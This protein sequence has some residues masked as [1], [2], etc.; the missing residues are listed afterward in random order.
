MTPP[1]IIKYMGSKRNILDFVVNTILEIKEPTD[2]RFYDVFG[3]TGVVS[4]AFR[5]ILAVTCNDIQNYTSILAK[6]YL[7]NYNWDDFPENIT[8]LLFNQIQEKITENLESNEFD[9]DYSNNITF[10]QFLELEANQKEIKNLDFDSDYHLFTKFYSGTYWSYSQCV[11]IDSISEVLRSD[12][13]LNTFWNH[14]GLSSLMFSMA[15]T[16]IGTGHYAQYRDPEETNMDDFL[17]YR[18]KSVFELFK[19]KLL[20]LIDHFRNEESSEFN[21]EYTNL[22]FTEVLTDLEQNSIVYADPPYQ[23]VHYS[24]FYH[25]LETLVLYDYPEIK[26]KGRYRTDRHQS[27][28]CQ[29]SNV[30]KA[31]ADLFN[32]VFISNSKLILS[33]SNN[34]M[35]S[36]E[37]I[38]LIAENELPNYN[39]E[40]RTMGHTHS[41]M[42]RAKDKSREVEEVLV[43]CLPQRELL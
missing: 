15:Y 7:A 3:G 10:Q 19:K 28:F 4:A 21:H 9:F 13:Y 30:G 22:D 25:A 24:R 14:L 41:T 36:L 27:P 39:I 20:S 8:D 29:K 1:H 23:F 26:F 31:F 16:T 6:T 33:Y 32:K 38:V 5:N 18:R 17:L 34:G 11:E 12:K 40:I 2:Q 35:I 37:E 43:L 42:G